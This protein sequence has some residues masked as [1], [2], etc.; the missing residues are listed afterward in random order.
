MMSESKKED[1][2]PLEPIDEIRTI[3]VEKALAATQKQKPMEQPPRTRTGHRRSKPRNWIKPILYTAIIV[4][5]LWQFA[6][7]IQCDSPS[8]T[9]RPRSRPA[10][11]GDVTTLEGSI[12]D[13]IAVVPYK[14]DFERLTD[15]SVAGDTRGI[16]RMI[17]TGQILMVEHDTEVRIIQ[18]RFSGYEVRIEEGLFEGQSGWVVE[19]CVA[20]IRNQP[21]E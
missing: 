4:P 12:I 11:V 5:G 8:T 18:R 2:R 21:S 15:L 10:N 6:P 7:L 17:L 13:G 14:F 3:D 20:R 9:R 1:R 16:E 19:N